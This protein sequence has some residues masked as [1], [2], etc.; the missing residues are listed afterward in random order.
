[1]YPPPPSAPLAIVCPTATPSTVT[2]TT[3]DRDEPFGNIVY[4]K[5]PGPKDIFS[6][7]KLESHTSSGRYG[8]QCGVALSACRII[9]CNEKGYLTT[10]RIRPESIPLDN[11]V[12]NK[13]YY[14]LKGGAKAADYPICAFETWGYPHDD[15]PD[16]WKTTVKRLQHISG[17]SDSTY[18]ERVMDWDR[19][20]LYTGHVD[21]SDCAHLVPQSSEELVRL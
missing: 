3:V 4:F 20:C 8:V 18:A 1:M 9:A 7:L 17:G 5:R 21:G 16:E 6:L 15:L 14:R 13:Y 10:S 11:L 2:L 19:N 12:A